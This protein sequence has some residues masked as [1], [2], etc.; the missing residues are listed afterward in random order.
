VT[1]ESWTSGYVLELVQG[2]EKTLCN[3]SQEFKNDKR[4]E[5]EFEYIA[6]QPHEFLHQLK[7]AKDSLKASIGPGWHWPIGSFIDVGC[8]IGSKAYLAQRYGFSAHG[9][10]ITSKYVKIARRLLGPHGEVF[11]GDA[12]EFNYEPYDVIYFYWPMMDHTKELQLEQRIFDTAKKGAI[13]IG[14][15]I[16]NRKIWEDEKLVEPIKVDSAAFDRIWRKK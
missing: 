8:G 5:G 6:F 4:K 10:E 16:Q 15:G 7:V 11:E 13:I 9:V 1:T 2:L 14:N 12:R 3:D